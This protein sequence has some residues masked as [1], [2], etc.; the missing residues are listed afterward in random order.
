MEIIGNGMIA[1]ALKPMC[2]TCPDAVVFA[3][4]VADSRITAADPYERERVMLY[5][6]LQRCA[7]QGKRLVYFSSG[8]AVYGPV[9]G[10]R[11]ET[12][13]V[14]PVTPYGRHK[15]LC[16][17]VIRSSGAPYLILRL[18]NLVGTAQNPQQLIPSLVEQIRHGSV[19]VY[20]QASRD[21]LAVSDFAHILVALI[22]THLPDDTL[23]VATG[24][25]VKVSDLVSRLEQ[26][27]GLQAQ[28]TLIDAGDQQEFDV[29]RFRTLLPTHADFSGT[30]AEDVLR[31]YLQGAAE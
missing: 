23:V 7:A 27:M 15:V 24:R 12:T 6:A 19:T 17:T 3:S 4:G 18:A 13:P 16:E 25:S 28:R 8:G 14:Y 11:S 9:Q 30:Y 5:A 2:H 29:T 26:L 31:Q 10:P 21:L 1:Q 22:T 20:T